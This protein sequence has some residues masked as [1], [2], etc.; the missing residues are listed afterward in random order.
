MWIAGRSNLLFARVAQW[1]STR[2][3]SDRSLDRSQPRVPILQIYS[4]SLLARTLPFQGEE[5]G[6]KPFRSTKIYAK[7]AHLVEHL[8]EAQ[9]VAGSSP[10]LGTTFKRSNIMK[11]GKP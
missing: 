11:R 5:E 7:V 9:G 4:G 8:F 2:L 10:A 3:I 6:S 1:K